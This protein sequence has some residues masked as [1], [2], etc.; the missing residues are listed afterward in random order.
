MRIPDNDVL[1]YNSSEELFIE[2]SF[3]VTNLSAVEEVLLDKGNL[4]GIIGEPGGDLL[5]YRRNYGISYKGPNETGGLYL[6]N[7]LYETITAGIDLIYVGPEDPPPSESDWTTYAVLLSQDG[8]CGPYLDPPPPQGC[9]KATYYKN[10]EW[11]WEDYFGKDDGQVNDFPLYIGTGYSTGYSG[12][13]K[14]FSGYIEYIKI[15]KRM[16]APSAIEATLNFNPNKLNLKSKGKWITA[17]I[18]L[19]EEYNVNDIDIASVKLHYNDSS[20][21]AAWGDIQDNVYMVKFDRNEVETILNGMTGN[22]ELKVTGEVDGTSFEGSDKI[23]VK[24]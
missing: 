15:Y 19:P 17:Y 5:Y 3:K 24:N 6:I 23:R 22:V 10:G 13:V 12:G 16:E 8:S 11:I 9:I 18:E 2:I 21:D 4:K 7:I 1:D 14:P 20:L